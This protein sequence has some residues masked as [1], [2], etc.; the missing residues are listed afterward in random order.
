MLAKRTVVV[1]VL[2]LAACGESQVFL[3]PSYFAA[4]TDLIEF[5]EHEVGTET[6]QTLFIINKGELPLEL[7]EPHGNLL[8]GVFS[9]R[10]DER[11]V[12]SNQD[13]RA[14]VVFSPTEVREYE[15]TLTF[16]N[17]SENA[18]EFV[19][20]LRG[21]GLTRDPCRGVSCNT[22]PPSSC[23][24]STTSR[25]WDPVGRCESGACSYTPIEEECPEFGCDEAT[26]RC[27]QD[28]CL[29]VACNTPPNGCFFVQGAC[30][31]GA[32][33]YTANNGA[34]CDDGNACTVNDTCREGSCTGTPMTCQSPPAPTC[35]GN[36][37]RTWTSAGACSAGTCTYPH[38]DVNCAFGCDNGVCKG[39]PCAGGCDDGNPCTTDVCDPG[40]GCRHTYADGASCVRS[41]A[42]PTGRC[43]AGACLAVADVTCEKKVSLDFCL[44]TKVPGRCT[45]A[46]ECVVDNP[47]PQFQCD[48]C[49]SNPINFCVKCGPVEVCL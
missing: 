22:P 20:T 28:P 39:D 34:G 33:T 1:A 44:D 2:A 15:T 38:A 4:S 23:I 30:H 11:S 41:G 9:V 32:C 47:P 25:R 17:D 31:G 16:P 3:N 18:P 6:P 42:C 35:L 24:T 13:V 27:G 49:A 8:G 14:R 43:S 19:L 7:S 48:K 5:G 37:L 36:V 12:P 46:G 10:L 45:G 29:G 21:R 26:G 40:F